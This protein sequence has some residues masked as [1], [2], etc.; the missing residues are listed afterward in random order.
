M[1]RVLIDCERTKYPNTGLYHFCL[2]LGA[3]L[4]EEQ[5]RAKDELYFYV[6]PSMPAL[7]GKDQHYVVQ[8]PLHKFYQAGTGKFQVWH[9]TFQNSNY[10]P[11]NNKTRVVLTIHDLNF[12][13][14]RKSEPHRSGN[15]YERYS[16]I[17]TGPII[18]SV[19]PNIRGKP[20][21]IIFRWKEKPLK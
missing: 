6:P 19:S 4:V 21:L 7:F 13:I 2:Q 15:T 3:A 12:L 1:N 17:S 11:Y 10:R 5:D 9:S 20:L 16:V 8:H 14:E 18:L